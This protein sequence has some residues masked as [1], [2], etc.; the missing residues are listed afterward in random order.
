VVDRLSI[1][2]LHLDI[3][4]GRMAENRAELAACAEKA[5]GMGAK[6]IVA[7]E[8]AVSGY[9]FDSREEVAPYAETLTG[10]TVALMRRIALHYGVYFCAG[11]A[12]R[13]PATGIH[14]NSACVVGPDGKLTALHRKIAS[15]RRW[16]RPGS[17]SLSSVFDSP[18]GRIGALICADSYFGLLPRSMALHG[19]DL[20]LILANWPP[21]GLDPRRVWRARALENGVGVIACNR[22]GVDRRMDCR[23]C[24]SY[25]VTPRGD[26]LLDESG[27]SSRIWIVSYPLEGGAFGAE[28]RRA[29][30]AGR[31]PE[32]F[33]ALCLDVN[34]LAD[35]S[36]L[37][38]LPAG[39]GMEIRCMVPEGPKGADFSSAARKMAHEAS[40]PTL[41]V[42][43][44][45]IASIPQLE[46]IF[47][48]NG[49]A[50]VAFLTEEETPDGPSLH[51][52]SAERSV[53]LPPWEG[54]TMVD[55][56]PAR[57]GV[58]RADRLRHPEIVVALS[59]QGCDVIATCASA[60]TDDDRLLFGVKS[61]ERAVIAV[62]APDG[63]VICEP[64]AGHAP[65]K[66]TAIHGP[67]ECAA[68][69][70]TAPLRSKHFMDR[71]DMEVLLQR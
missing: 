26:V 24:S 58:A 22:T 53:V 60:L 62:C 1:A 9:S 52:L 21:S 61:L 57:I 41:I 29:A 51:F 69:I 30:M 66:E 47:P 18:W 55:F 2:L 8:L 32:E 3:R 15:E 5:A 12:E 20:L 34:G 40:T 46:A 16:A 54:A 50:P 23:D 68:R 59:K 27:E 42:L 25:A 39:G 49:A 70:H 11:F 33:E 4:Y 48:N 14:Y 13:D 19:V 35:F 31:S 17:F 45:N 43:P 71:V 67:G 38:N 56:G 65:W 44:G 63:A 10:E 64:P 36:G 37:W 6:L 28:R 7:P